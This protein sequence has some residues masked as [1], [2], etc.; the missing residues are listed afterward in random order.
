MQTK[1]SGRA[2]GR[3]NNKL[4]YQINCDKLHFISILNA[5]LTY[6]EK[7]TDK[8]KIKHTSKR[9]IIFY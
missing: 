4:T 2:D 5:Q 1:T 6:V 7:R 8:H 3:R 9:E